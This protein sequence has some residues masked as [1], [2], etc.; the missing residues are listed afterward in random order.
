MAWPLR[1]MSAWLALP[2]ASAMRRALVDQDLG[3]HDVDAGDLL[4][5]G[6]LDLHA[7][8][9][10]DEVELARVAVHQELDRAGALVVGGAGDLQAELADVVPLRLGQVGRRRALDD[11]LVPPLHRAVALPEVIDG[12]LLVA[13]DLHLDVAGVED[14][15]LEVAL[16]VAEGGQRLAPALEHLLLELV[17]AHD[18]PHAAA[19]AAPARLEHEG[20]ADRVGHPPHLVHVVGQHLGRRD[21]RHAGRDRHLARARLVAEHPHGLGRRADEGDA[22]RGRRRRRSRGSPTAGRSPDGSRPRR[23]SSPRG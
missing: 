16:A 21:D 4:G 19:A 12:A 20:I 18:R 9:H 8:V 3:A 15:L 17:G 7:R 14:H 13:E 11:L 23:S 1:V 6:V 2:V 22:G 10:L 5:H